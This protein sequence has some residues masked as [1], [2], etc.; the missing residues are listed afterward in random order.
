MSKSGTL[1]VKNFF[2]QKSVDKEN[3]EQ[4]RSGSLGD[5]VPHIPSSATLPA[6]SAPLS[7][8][9]NVTLPDDVL[10]TSPK[11][12]KKRRI[13]SSLR[14]KRK[15]SKRDKE[16]GGEEVFFPDTDELD[17]FNSHM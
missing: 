11:E 9:E 2:K 13:F 1:R 17:S 14:L 3:K 8:G 10:P 15:K 4:K 16:A 5:A 12:K 6:T 7:P